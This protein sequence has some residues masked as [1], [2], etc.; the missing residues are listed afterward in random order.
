MLAQRFEIPTNGLQSALEADV[1]RRL[2]E[3]PQ[4]M[5]GASV[6]CLIGA[7]LAPCVAVRGRLRR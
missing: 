7:C 4:W 1:P 5:F 3:I 2:L 6:V